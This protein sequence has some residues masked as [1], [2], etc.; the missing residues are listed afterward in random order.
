MMQT[1]IQQRAIELVEK[2]GMP[3][4]E[5][6]ELALTEFGIEGADIKELQ[7]ECSGSDFLVCDDIPALI[8]SVLVHGAGLLARGNALQVVNHK[9]QLFN[10]VLTGFLAGFLL[11]GSFVLFIV[12]T[13]KGSIPLVGAVLLVFAL[14][15]TWRADLSYKRFQQA[16][17]D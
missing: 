16:L 17:A 6:E 12:E 9:D 14:V 15:S 11:S 1:A 7:G 3:W 2:A 13:S 10:L 4:Q 8:R 5:A